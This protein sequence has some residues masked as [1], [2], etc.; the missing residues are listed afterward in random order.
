[1]K[2]V[3]DR[4]LREYACDPELLFSKKD[5]FRYRQ[6]K[7]ARRKREKRQQRKEAE[8]GSSDEDVHNKIDIEIESF[9]YVRFCLF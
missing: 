8:C 1:M 9:Y 5:S 3:E 2:K 4:Y 6:E 7:Y